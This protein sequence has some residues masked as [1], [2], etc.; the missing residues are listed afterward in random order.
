[1]KSAIG[2]LTYR[3][4]NSLRLFLEQ[5]QAECSE[6]PIAVFED[7]GQTDNTEDFLLEGATFVERNHEFACDIYQRGKVTVFLSH[8]NA[9]VCGNSNKAIKWFMER[10]DAEHLCLCNDDLEA[11]GPF[12]LTYAE[13]HKKLDIG[14]FCFSDFTS[15]EYKFV[16][17][18][19]RGTKV[20]IL[21]RMTGIMMSFTRKLVEEIG[22]YDA[23][24]FTFGQEHCDFNN[25]ARLKGFINLNGQPQYSLDVPCPWLKHQDVPSSLTNEEKQRYNQHADTMIDIVAKSYYNQDLFRPYSIGRVAQTVGGRDGIGIPISE[26]SRSLK[27]QR[28]PYVSADLEPMIGR[29]S[30][31]VGNPSEAAVEVGAEVSAPKPTVAVEFVDEVGAPSDRLG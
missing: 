23:M 5:V 9:G 22:Y 2:I 13:A 30:E 12:Y 18:P 10:T 15:D 4:V 19:V 3:R 24:T 31:V 1:M 16:T 8:H 29:P 17:V 27:V 21:T 7:C 11:T 20:K 25:R 6:V 14:L 28:T 26:L